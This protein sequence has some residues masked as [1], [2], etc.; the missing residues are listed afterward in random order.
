M[1]SRIAG[2]A[3][4]KEEA[5]PRAAAAIAA[6]ADR[7]D[8]DI[9]SAGDVNRAAVK[10]RGR[11]IAKTARAAIAAA[12]AEGAAAAAVAASAADSLREKAA[13][14]P[15]D[16]LAIESDRHRSAIDA[17]TAVAAVASYAAAPSASALRPL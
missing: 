14:I 1:A 17:W 16:H 12:A 5:A 10:V 11:D 8:P 15:T 2:A 9:A 7:R 6:L 4:R 3:A 13:L